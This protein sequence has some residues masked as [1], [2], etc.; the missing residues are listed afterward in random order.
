MAFVNSTLFEK[1]NARNIQEINDKNR[2]KWKYDKGNGIIK[3][4]N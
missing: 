4:D 2:R 1:L 3:R